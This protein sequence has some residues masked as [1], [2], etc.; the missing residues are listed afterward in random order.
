MI[1]RFVLHII[2]N[3]AALYFISV[4]LN[5]DFAVTGGIP[6]YLVAALIFGILNTLVKPI[7]KILAFPLMLITVG[8]FSFVLNMIVVWLAKYTL[9]VLAFQGIAVHV[10]HIAAYF[11]AGLLLAIANMLIHW[12][13][14]K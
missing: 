6:G 13:T 1:K 12:L 10:E 5:G 8:L 2:A 14:S 4:L 3:A 9:D 11:Y 7:L